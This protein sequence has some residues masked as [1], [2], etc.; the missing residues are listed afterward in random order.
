MLDQ[1][2]PRVE[3]MTPEEASRA[4]KKIIKNNQPFFH[5]PPALTLDIISKMQMPYES[6]IENCFNLAV[7]AHLHFSGNAHGGDTSKTFKGEEHY[8][9]LYL[10]MLEH[11]HDWFVF[12]EDDMNYVWPER[13]VGILGTL[14]TIHRNRH[15]NDLCEKILDLDECVLNRYLEMVQNPQ[16]KNKD[17]ASEKCA[18]GLHYKYC[19]IRM[20]LWC[21]SKPI[22]ELTFDYRIETKL[23]KCFRK[24][25]EYESQ[26]MPYDDDADYLYLVQ[27]IYKFGNRIPDVPFLRA[28][29]D[30][31]IGETIQYFLAMTRQTSP[32]EMDAVCDTQKRKCTLAVCAGCSKTEP[33]L[34]TFKV[35][36][37]CSK[38]KYCSKECQVNHWKI[39]KTA[40]H[41][42]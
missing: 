42:K 38:V 20:N 3:S 12:F 24:L 2:D 41:K 36:S 34:K 18:S 31:Q 21:Q 13:I 29:T 16:I 15:D 40:C 1:Q 37:R 30:K 28:L 6:F 17:L 26:Y 33:F 4:A 27:S 23:V 25:I 39:H 22:S 11:R 32:D 14:A 10:N 19:R 8:Y 5:M 9:R 7:V 35:C